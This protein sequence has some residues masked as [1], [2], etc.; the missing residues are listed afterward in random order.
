MVGESQAQNGSKAENGRTDLELRDNSL[1]TSTGRLSI[2]EENKEMCV[3]GWV[4]KGLG[5]P[6][7]R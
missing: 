2:W 1:I 5:C 6:I 7:K 4:G 3:A